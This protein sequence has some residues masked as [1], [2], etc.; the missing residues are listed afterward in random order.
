[1]VRLAEQGSAVLVISQD[2]DELLGL[3]DRL[4]VLNQGRLGPA[5]PI[6]EWTVERLSHA[7]LGEAEAPGT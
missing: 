3:C 4:A 2:L 7:M 1:M 6:G 5:K